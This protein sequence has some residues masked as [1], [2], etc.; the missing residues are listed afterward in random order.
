MKYRRPGKN[1]PEVSV[2]GFGAWSVGGG[3]GKVDENIGIDT[4]RTAI[5]SGITLINTARG[6]LTSEEVVGKALRDGYRER[7]FLTTQPVGA[8][9]SI[10]QI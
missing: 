5:D 8:I 4:V 7:C 2:I 9:H 3:M 10:R 6:Y 1:G